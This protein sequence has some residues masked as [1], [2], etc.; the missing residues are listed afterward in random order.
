M[1]SQ[2]GNRRIS[3]VLRHVRPPLLHA[4]LVATTKKGVALVVG[5]GDAT[6][7]AAAQAFAREGYTVVAVRRDKGASFG[8]LD[9]LTATI[10][11]EG[12]EA[13]GFAV[14]AR[15]EEE[16]VAL[17]NDIEERLGPIAVAIHNIGP[18]VRQSV[19]DMTVERYRKIFDLAA[20]SAFVVGREVVRRM[21]ARGHGGCV[22]FTGATA[23]VRGNSGF[24]AFAGAMAAKR[25]LAQ[26]M[27]REFGPQGI[28]VAHVIV[29]GIIDTPFHASDASPVPRSSWKTMKESEGLVDPH[30]IA[31][32]FVG[33][34]KQPRST[35]TFE[36]DL[37]P[38]SETW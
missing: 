3:S 27:A 6:G 37:R 9:D 26:S 14:D 15:N 11:R 32:A 17:L 36:L 25:M 5:A 30:A 31:Q 34:A 38:W 35:W 1:S 7:A 13:H 10:R 4:S 19:L 29:D 18:N 24:A 2:S 8:S 12:G 22:I 20:G 16:V 23:S 28:H 21:V 33:L